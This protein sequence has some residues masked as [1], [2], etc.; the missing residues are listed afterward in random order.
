VE[1]VVTLSA[2]SWQPRNPMLKVG[3]HRRGL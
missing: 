3:G 2:S 1:A